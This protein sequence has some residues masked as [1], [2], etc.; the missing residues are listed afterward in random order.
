MRKNAAVLYKIQD[1]EGTNAMRGKNSPNGIWLARPL[2]SENLY[3]LVVILKK[4]NNIVV[5]PSIIYA[6]IA[7]VGGHTCITAG[8]RSEPAD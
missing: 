7:P 4:G 5:D 3:L 2:V 6:C 8:E 1:A